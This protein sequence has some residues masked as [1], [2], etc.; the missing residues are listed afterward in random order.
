MIR[1]NLPCYLYGM[2]LAAMASAA[3]AQDGTAPLPPLQKERVSYEQLKARMAE[4]AAKHP[5]LHKRLLPT[6]PASRKDSLVRINRHQATKP[7]PASRPRVKGL[8]KAGATKLWGNVLF[9][10]TWG[11]SYTA[12]GMYTFPTTAP[13]TVT[14]AF[15]DDY[16]RATGSGAWVDDTLYYVWYQNFWGID[17]Y[18]LYKWNTDTWEQVG[19]EESLSDCSLVANETAVAK[20]GTVYGDF[21]DADGVNNELGVA[22]Y[23][24]K[25]RTTIG[26]LKQA[27]VAMGI[28]SDDTLY[29]IGTDGGLYRIDT[30]TA[31]ETFIGSTGVTLTK[32]D[33]SF[34]YQRGS[35]NVQVTPSP[36]PSMT[37]K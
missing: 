4:S 28:T 18:Y 20:D 31:T 30:A 32:A 22:D 29:G 25:T 6:P 1:T 24:N 2:A 17:M 9:D 26:R 7:T 34:Y 12:Y 10:S 36:S 35:S 19:T 16:F 27:Y 11:D 3:H 8:A 33:G 21:L 14:P 13:V 37:L 5:L 23:A 15:T